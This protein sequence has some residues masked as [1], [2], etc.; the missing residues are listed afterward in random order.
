MNALLDPSEI[1]RLLERLLDEGWKFPV[2]YSAIS[3]DGSMVLGK[4]WKPGEAEVITSH[5][6]SGQ[7]VLPMNMMLVDERGQAAL[8]KWARDSEPV[9]VH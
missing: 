4:Y 5:C 8:V 2:H 9:I 1:A 3:N 6:P 7:F